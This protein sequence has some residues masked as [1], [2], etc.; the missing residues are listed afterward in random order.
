[1]SDRK[2]ITKL[3]TLTAKAIK[4][5]VNDLVLP[6]IE[7][8]PSVAYPVLHIVMFKNC[9]RV[10]IERIVHQIN[11]SYSDT[12]YDACFVMIRRLIETLIIEVY[13]AKG[14]DHKIKDPADGTFKML[15]GLIAVIK[16]ETAFNVDRNSKKGLDQI[17]KLGDL[18]AHNRRYNA[19]RDAIDDIKS[20][21][22][23]IVGELLTLAGM[24]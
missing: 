1:M 11:R 9:N 17:K 14:L 12:C 3:A 8:I 6:A 20:D 10:Y 19:N 22:R 15:E 13:E 18:S 5:D 23:V 2:N 24:R 4:D 21:L 7:T 16:N